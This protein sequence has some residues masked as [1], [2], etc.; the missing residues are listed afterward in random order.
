VIF[1]A[2]CVG[3]GFVRAMVFNELGISLIVFSTCLGWI[4]VVWRDIHMKNTAQSI[5]RQ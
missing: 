2:I 1:I 3:S 4:Q 5:N